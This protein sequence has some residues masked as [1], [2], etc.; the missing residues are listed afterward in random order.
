MK[1]KL[2]TNPKTIVKLANEGKAV[3]NDLLKH[4]QPAAFI[5][6]YYFRD[7]MNLIKRKVF[8]TYIRKEGK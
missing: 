7:V 3:W 1:G 6:N 8:Y 5:Q 2:I 4:H